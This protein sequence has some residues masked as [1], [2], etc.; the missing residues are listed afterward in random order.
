MYST[1]RQIWSFLENSTHILLTCLFVLV[2]T[3]AQAQQVVVK[4]NV[5][6]A[7]GAPVP[8]A[9]VVIK[10]TTTGTIT[11]LNG[12]YTLT[13]PGSDAV[14]AISYIGF[15]SQEITVGSQTD[16]RVSLVADIAQ[17][18]EVVVVGYGTQKRSDLTGAIASV[19]PQEI[20]SFPIARVDQALQGRAPG[21]Y[22]LNSDGS[23]GGNTLIRIRG[24]NSINGG[25]EPLVVIDGLQGGDLNSLNPQDIEA[26]EILKDASATAIYGSRGANGVI[27]VTTKQGKIGKPVIEANY[28]VGFQELARKLPTMTAVEYAETYN[29]I[30]SKQTANGNVP[31]PVFTDAE[32]E[33]FR[34]NGGT[35]WQD[36]VYQTGVINN[37]Q[38][39]I[40]G[41]TEGMRY[42]VSANYL[43]HKG[44]IIGSGYT[45]ASLRANL[46]ANI[47]D[48]LEFGMAWNYT[49]EN[50]VGADF[51]GDEEAWLSQVVNTSARW[52]PTE[53]VY[54]EDGSYHKHG[55]YGA[56]D[57][58]NPMIAVL[59]PIRTN[60][61][62]RNNATLYL[63]YKILDG[64]TFRVQGSGIY[65]QQ[66]RSLYQN[67]LTR[68]GTGANGS[69]RVSNT[70]GTRYQN[71][72]ILTYD[73]AI[74]LHRF[75]ATG[76]F[77]SVWEEFSSS[78]IE[79]TD[80]LVDATGFN[81]LGAANA[82]TASSSKSTRTL[83]SWMGRVNYVYN[84]KYLATV[85]FRADASS[86][87]G[88][89]NKW[90]Y[91]PSLSLAWRL[92]E[93]D[94]MSNSGVDLKLRGSWGITGNQ[95]ISPFQSLPRLN[96]GQLYP[97]NGGSNTNIGF[98]VGAI[99]NPNLKWEETTQTNIGI[100]LSLFEGRLTSTI[101]VYKKTTDDLLM[102]RELPGYV[103]IPSVL[104]NVGSIENKGVEVQIGGDP[105]VGTFSWNTSLNF[106]LN[107]NKVLDLG[108]DEQIAFSTTDG[109]YGLNEFMVLRVGEP[110][111]TMTG[112]INDGVW[113]TADEA[114]AR[115]YGQL[116]GMARFRDLNGDGQVDIDDRTIIGN[117]FP[118]FTMGW[119][120]SL[121][122][123]NFNL[124]FM[125]LTFQGVD[126]FNTLRIRREVS[127]EGNSK[128]MLDAWTPENQDTDVPG[129]LDG[130]T[131]EGEAL[132]NK[133][134]LD[135]NE[136]SR[137]VEDASF[138]RLKTMTLSYTFDQP[139]LESIGVVGLRAFV[140]GTNLFTIT[141]Y[142]GYDPEVS[143]YTDN[144][145]QLGVDFAV[146][147][148]A[149]TYTIG[150]EFNF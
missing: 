124:N 20:S 17:L 43:D 68:E 16:I 58:W 137:Y 67:K 90:G 27:L 37:A 24:L 14:L 49:R 9:N 3:E 25:N 38:V 56:S 13:V 83:R 102:P 61:E 31:I 122:Y 92:S 19:S 44:I 108:A 89:D 48:K 4:G 29:L 30:R 63:S 109:G 23:P 118:D 143:A 1:L 40:S 22:V 42:M 36:V 60:P 107:R 74:G 142:T 94:F 86:V 93:E 148:P 150:V 149:K 132:E 6:D 133:Y 46:T 82:L 73:K 75:T 7:T 2:I 39:G 76:L 106:T 123:K 146:Y 80:F 72:N 54:D 145:A 11:D 121:S 136:S 98:G 117:A 52:A 130:A 126:L 84:D 138:I 21:V 32:I 113:G 88:T 62:T 100:D 135:G 96:S 131:V 70:L 95:G 50:A 15:V 33:G 81:D 65:D 69:A 35:D 51:T 66:N 8:G 115:S 119:T 141:D 129:Y 64:L 144:D 5:S 99:A 104:D 45:R 91:F 116:P 110:F 105:V 120:N 26:L 147:P 127:W 140:S 28:S 79:A 71:S 78:R 57:T 12:D 77:E 134:F 87:F 97:Y 139:W 55:P 53:P 47:T 101:D 41:G 111:G 59:E 85:S 103:G 114:Q 34:R 18:E 112:Y 10:G 125:F 128:R